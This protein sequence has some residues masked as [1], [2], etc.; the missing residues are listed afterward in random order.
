[1]VPGW[2]RRER[3]RYHGCIGNLGG[4]WREVGSR[5]R[6]YKAAMQYPGALRLCGVLAGVLLLGCVG[7]DKGGGP[8]PGSGGKAEGSGG[9]GGTPAATGGSAA[10]RSGGSGTGGAV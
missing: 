3:E 7:D 5:W 10:G 9:S 8:D 1:M 6:V 4:L 2:W